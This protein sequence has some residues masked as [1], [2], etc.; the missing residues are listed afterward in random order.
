MNLLDYLRIFLR[1]SWIVALAVLVMAGSAYLFSRAQTP[2]YRA[3]QQVSVQPARN[4]FGLAETLRILL[5]SYVIILD[6]DANAQEIINRTQV[7]MTP[8][9]LRTATTINSDPTTL[10]VS[11]A[12]DLEDG[13]QAA[14]LANT[15]GQLLVEWREQ[16]NSDLRREDRIQANLLDYPGWGQHRPNT[17][18]NVLAAS[19]LGLLLGGMV[20]FVLEYLEAN[21]LRAS[22]DAERWLNAPVLATITTET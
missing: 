9:D 6:T 17:R 18:V 11:I 12:V 14:Q 8:G 16:Q 5:R 13:P 10:V 15:W 1:R 19:V 4:D 22:R 3:T 7:D 20:I 2:V 21:V